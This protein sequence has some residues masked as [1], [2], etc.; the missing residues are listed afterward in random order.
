MPK[1]TDIKSILII[2]SGPIVI[3]QACEFDYSGSQACKALRQEGYRVILVN[4]NPATIMTDPE[5]ADATYIEPLTVEALTAVIAKERPD[6]LLPT[7]G[8]QTGLNLA[9]ALARAGVLEQYGVELIGASAEVIERAEDRLLFRETM[10]A[11]GLDVLRSE[12]V[13]SVEAAEAFARETGYPVIIRP[14]FTLGGTGGG[15]AY[16]QDDLVRI[17]EGGLA[18]SPVHTV[19]VEES[20]LG[21][22]E[23]ELE[24]MRDKA[25][26]VV[27]VCSIENLDPMGVHT[28]D[29]ITVAPSQT[30]TDREYQAMRNAAIACMQAI[31]VETGGAN[32]QFAVEP[33]TG[34]MVIIEMN[35]RVSRSS[36]LAS[37]ATG[38]PI[39]K[40]AALVAVGYTLD[41]IPNDITKTTPASFEPAIDYCVVK[42]PRFDFNKFPEA[43]PTLGTQMKAVGEVMAIGRTFKEALQKALRSLEI[44]WPGLVGLDEGVGVEQ[45]RQ[46]LRVPSPDRLAAVATALRLGVPAAE[47]CALTGIDPWFVDQIGELVQA[48]DELRA[49]AGA[50][51]ERDAV[52]HDAVHQDAVG[53]NGAGADGAAA[54]AAPR[55]AAPERLWR[56][57]QLGFSDKQ[58][59]QAVGQAE[60][61]VRESR[62]AAGVRPAYKLVDTCAG[63]FEAHTPYFYSAYE[64]ES[65]AR[66]D[67]RPSIVILGGG[68]NRIGQG[69]EFD[70]CCVQAAI[71]A[72]ELGYA[73]A[74]VNC[75]PETVS[76]DYDISDRLYFEPLTLEDVLHIVEVEQPVGVIV[77]FGGQTPLK[78]AMALKRAG[79]PIL[80]TSPESIHLAEDRE[81]FQRLLNELGL[82]QAPGVTV[83]S[84]EEAKRAAVRLGY[85]VLVR[86]S[87]VLGGRAME[88]V[89]HEDHLER[90]VRAALAV[91]PEQPILIDTYLRDAIELDVDAV[92]DG[93]RVAV[94]GILEHV[95]EAGVHSGDSACSIPA[96]R[97]PK[98]VADEVVRQVRVLAKALRVV[99]LMNVQF[100]WTGDEL[101][102]LE[103]NPRA[104]R[105]VPFVSKAVGVPL[106]RVATRVMLGQPLDLPERLP[107]PQEIAVKE[108]VFP[109]G[110][111]DGVDPV[112]GPEM[113]STGEVMAWGQDLAVAYWK[114]QAA[115]GS[116]LPDGGTV[117]LQ[118]GPLRM[119]SVLPAAQL[120]EKLGLTLQAEPATAE[121]LAGKGVAVGALGEEEAASAMVRGE[122]QMLVSLPD[123]GQTPRA[124]RALRQRAIRCNVP[125]F[126]TGFGAHLA[127]QA[128]AAWRER[129]SW[130]VR[131]LQERAQTQEQLRLRLQARSPQPVPAP[132]VKALAPTVKALP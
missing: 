7:M 83:H 42:V 95:E 11:A 104:S 52:H 129:G 33:R 115:A 19:L 54:A 124:G 71:A 89:Y 86:P 6:A 126:T 90:Y 59:A 103:V 113:R 18:D 31:G 132:P 15:I 99:G 85:P 23:F 80:G 72:R 27:I 130:Q 66:R 98:A 49:V 24:L 45:V 121:Y 110:K 2:G 48:E 105:T 29:S 122:I 28:G 22:K 100:A 47:I 123:P 4:S 67:G 128:I 74:M 125:L 26:N 120:L 107:E 57:K 12:L 97:L 32:V 56:F 43:D 131:S 17:V 92:S 65:E 79:V 81:A 39:A 8:G 82:K 61:A 118:A 108:V 111:F 34:R 84:V 20:A 5:M 93:E 46:A 1:R 119:A 10:R 78:L 16:N 60:A 3:G 25:G 64:R 62:R 69:I 9:F 40:I 51:R 117:Y 109:F 50:P 55:W 116:R 21:W 102:V 36:A 76:T 63:E 87:Y 13:S 14:S 37:K 106:A 127:A 101:Y 44:G 88:I 41:E 114:A 91:D 112:L 30:L 96:T 68:P 77:Q 58:I 94:A 70:Y 75:N 38:Y 35:P 53:L 73:V